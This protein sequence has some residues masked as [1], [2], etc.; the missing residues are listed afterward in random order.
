MV[1]KE[2]TFFEQE[3]LKR[4]ELYHGGLIPAI[5]EKIALGRAMKEKSVDIVTD[6]KPSSLFQLAARGEK[7]FIVG[8]W[9]NRQDFQF[10]GAKGLK[11]LADLKGKKIGTR[12]IGGIGHTVLSLQLKRAALDPAADVIFVR[13]ARFHPNERPEETLR[14]GEVD[15]IHVHAYDN[16]GLERDG[17]PI[18]LE[19]RK[20]YPGGRPDRVIVATRRMVEE[21][22]DLLMAYLRATIRAYWFMTDRDNRPY[23]E[24]LVRRLRFSCL[25]EE[26]AARSGLEGGARLS[27]PYDGA[28]SSVGL[29]QMLWET[30]EMGEIDKDFEIEPILRLEFVQRALQELQ[31]RPELKDQIALVR[32]IYHQREK[33]WASS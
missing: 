14:S 18:L 21:D 15:C 20:L 11:S 6:V 31:S 22:A 25:D 33:A 26:E 3:G 23:L 28:P 27:L 32:D 8:C 29:K 10:F 9:R 7:L 12:D 24:A 17:Y 2:M 5:A 30:Q 16:R 1:A 13:G 4:Y 19:S